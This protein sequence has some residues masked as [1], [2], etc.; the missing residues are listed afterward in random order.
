LSLLVVVV[1]LDLVRKVAVVVQVD[2][3]HQRGHLAV[4]R[5]LKIYYL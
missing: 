1:V 5:L 4:V 3:E 2:I